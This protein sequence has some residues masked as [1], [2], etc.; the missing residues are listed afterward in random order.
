MLTLRSPRTPKR[1]SRDDHVVV[2]G[3][4]RPIGGAVDTPTGRSFNHGGIFYENNS[5]LVVGRRAEFQRVS[6]GLVQNGIWAY[7]FS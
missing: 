7:P 4:R 6:A 1:A 3:Q 5:A 2:C